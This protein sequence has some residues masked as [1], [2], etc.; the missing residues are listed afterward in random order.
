MANKTVARIKNVSRK[1]RQS[2]R[3][4][5]RSKASE[6]TDDQVDRWVFLRGLGAHEGQWGE[7][8]KIFLRHHPRAE[9]HHL[10]LR[11]NG[12]RAEETSL[13]TMLQNV[14]DLRERLIKKIGVG[15]KFNFIGTSMGAMAGI[16]WYIHHPQDFRAIICIGTS[17]GSQSPF[18]HRVQIQNIRGVLALA[19]KSQGMNTGV[20]NL[21]RQAIAAHFHKF[22]SKRPKV[23]TLLLTSAEDKFTHPDCTL[24]LAAKWKIEPHVHPTA[25]HDLPVE[26]PEWLAR[27]IKNFLQENFP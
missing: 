9:V 3:K 26:D 8:E 21:I 12:L 16:E 20:L 14:E 15:R 25:G 17:D 19:D 24:R 18:Y 5:A 6:A 4:G 1:V 13:L 22:P 2:L 10:T 11:G 7:F 23:P 27:K